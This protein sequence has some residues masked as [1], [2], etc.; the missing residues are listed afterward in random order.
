MFLSGFVHDKKLTLLCIVMCDSEGVMYWS[1]NFD[2]IETAYINGSGRRPL[3]TETFSYYSDFVFHDGDIYITDWFCR[4]VCLYSS[5]SGP[6]D[7]ITNNKDTDT[8]ELE[9]IRTRTFKFC[10]CSFLPL[11]LVIL[12]VAVNAHSVTNN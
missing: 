9:S 12:Q 1:D 6:C 4:Y 7:K 2:I 8:A 3:L 11:L 5:A 10:I